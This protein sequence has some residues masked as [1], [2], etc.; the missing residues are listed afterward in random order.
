MAKWDLSQWRAKVENDEYMPG[1]ESQ[2]EFD[3]AERI[4]IISIRYEWGQLEGLDV[5][6]G[7]RTVSITTRI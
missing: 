1:G 7:K 2:I 6:D 5:T 3:S 4:F